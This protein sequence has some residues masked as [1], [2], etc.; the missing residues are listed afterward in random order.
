LRLS[1][2]TIALRWTLLRC[3]LI[4]SRTICYTGPRAVVHLT[5]LLPLISFV[6]TFDCI[7]HLLYT[8]CPLFN[9]HDLLGLVV[10]HISHIL[11]VV[12]LFI[13]AIVLRYSVIVTFVY[14]RLFVTALPRYAALRC[15]Y[16]IIPVC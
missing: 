16:T 5:A 13:H 8:I 3:V 10:V 9:L 14:S 2:I 7:T 12:L 15:R 1:T 11:F 4:V 6:D